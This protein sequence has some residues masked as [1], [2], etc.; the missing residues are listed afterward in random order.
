MV[1]ALVRSIEYLFDITDSMRAHAWDDAEIAR[2]A[3]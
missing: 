3:E 2:D 1:P